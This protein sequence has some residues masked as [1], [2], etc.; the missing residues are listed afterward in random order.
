MGASY[1]RAISEQNAEV[2][3]AQIYKGTCD[4]TCQNLQE[5]ISVDVIGSVLGGGIVFSQSCSTNGNCIFGN[6]MDATADVFFKATNSSN[7]KNAWSGW[8]MDPFSYDNAESKSRQN[9]KEA[10]T[11]SVT[12]KCKIS[13][14]N[15]MNNIS[16]FAANSQLGGGIE[17]NQKGTTTGKCT[18]DNTMSAAAYATGMAQ[19]TASSGKD[20]KAQKFGDKSSIF[21]LLTYL[22][23]G[24]V[25]LIVVIIVAK[26]IT[27]HMRKT[28]LPNTVPRFGVRG[29]GGR[30]PPVEC[31]SG[32][33]LMLD[34]TTRMFSCA[35][36]GAPRAPRVSAR[37][38]G[39][40]SRPTI[41]TSE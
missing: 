15:Q 4:M 38:A 41:S 40:R 17:F 19:N 33:Q 23:I 5:N 22:G 13:S 37:A 35:R 11:E 25:V 39:T 32:S 1:S 29:P 8:T 21:R 34:P 10:I 36:V 6:T 9:I 16:V 28:R 2:D 14:Y 7:A 24:L 31:P 12:E 27:S 26:L 3:L 18:L 30:I 20:K